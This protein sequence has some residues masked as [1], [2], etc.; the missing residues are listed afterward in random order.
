MLF[1]AE[2]VL[3]IIYIFCLTKKN[4]TSPLCLS[5]LN[6]HTIKHFDLKGLVRTHKFFLHLR[7]KN[8]LN[9]ENVLF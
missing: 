9:N 6:N 4:K 7:A 3:S 8:H 1:N 2:V 5:L